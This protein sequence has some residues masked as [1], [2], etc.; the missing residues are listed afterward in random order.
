MREGHHSTIIFIC[1]VQLATCELGIVCLINTFISEIFTDF[2]HL[3]YAP[4]HQFFQVQLRRNPQEQISFMVVMISNKWFL[5]ACKCT[6]MAPPQ[7]G[8]RIGV[9]TST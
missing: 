6:A 4:N 3:Q 7:L 1:A 5:H 8:D 9:S 2:E